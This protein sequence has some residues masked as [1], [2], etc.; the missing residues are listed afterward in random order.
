MVA[1]GVV[2]FHSYCSHLAQLPLGEHYVVVDLV[3]LWDS[4]C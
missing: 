3:V 1:L 4:K 2:L